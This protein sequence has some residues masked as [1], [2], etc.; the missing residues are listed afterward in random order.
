MEQT[1]EKRVKILTNSGFKYFGI[2]LKE[3]SIFITIRDERQ[4]EIK[5]PLVNIS[6]MQEVS[7]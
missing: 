3:D 7:R 2:L 6:F 5:V 4:G 1:N